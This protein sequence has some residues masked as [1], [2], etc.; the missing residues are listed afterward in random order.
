VELIGD[1][2]ARRELAER[3]YQ[4]FAARDQAAILEAALAN[5][6][7]STL[8]STA[9]D[10]PSTDARLQSQDHSA[11]L[12]LRERQ[13]FK[14]KFAPDRDL[15]LANVERNPDD[16]RSVFFLAET[17]WQ[18]D[19]FAEARKWYARRIEM[20][21][22]DEEVYWA[23]YRLAAS[24]AELGEP[25]S[26][27]EDAYLRAWQFRPSRAEAL[28]AIAFR[29]RTEQRYE[30][31]Y[32]YAKRAAD[33]PFPEADLFVL[34]YFAEIYAWRATDEQA[35]CAFWIG[36][37]AE[38]F[39]L[40]R[41]LLGRADLPDADRQRIATN[42]DF[43]V[44][45]MIEATAPYPE[46]LVHTLTTGPR[47][48]EVTATLIARPDRQTSEH[49]LK[50]FLNCCLDVS[51]VA[52]FLVLDTGLSA[53][54]RAALQRRYG[55]LTFVDGG[56]GERPAAQLAALRVHV[57]GRFWLHLCEGWRFFAPENYVTRLTAILDAEP[58]VYRVGI[59]IA[60]ASKLNGTS[61]PEHAIRRTPI[62]GRY[63]LTDATARGP[64][65]FDTARL[66]QAVGVPSRNLYSSDRRG[67]PATGTELRTASLDEVLCISDLDS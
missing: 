1:E 43:S 25:W 42:R 32:E 12:Q 60:D 51:R 15:W 11:E 4:T 41:R 28:Y 56:P 62:A 34:G 66:D 35:T 21:G 59:N 2:R 67:R 53:P 38:A 61:A 63:I 26:D 39:E 29:Y 49:T 47:D 31:G 57:A 16:A 30:L 9:Q 23:M 54:D 17:S 33:I 10:D 36:R 24:M 45:A 64:A 19:D 6:E 22:N 55:F 3:G 50:S 14:H 20:G 37:R 65:M 8:R 5:L 7:D 18:L 46:T 52:R 13:L 40:C 44:P 48:A 58:L 27:V